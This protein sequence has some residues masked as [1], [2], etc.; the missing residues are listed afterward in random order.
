MNKNPLPIVALVIA[1]ALAD[2]LWLATSCYDR[3]DS[4][5]LAIVFRS[6]GL[7]QMT[8]IGMWWAIG[9]ANYWWRLTATVLVVGIWCLGLGIETYL[10]TQYDIFQV[11]LALALL[12]ILHPIIVVP[13]VV[14]ISFILR[15]CGLRR[16]YLW[17]RTSSL[18]AARRW[19]FWFQNF[20]K[21]MMTLAIIAVSVGASG[22]PLILL[23]VENPTVRLKIILGCFLTVG[24]AAILII[25]TRVNVR[26][27]LVVVVGTLAATY[28]GFLQVAGVVRDFGETRVEVDPKALVRSMPPLLIVAGYFSF[29]GIA[30]TLAMLTPKDV[31]IKLV[32]FVA[33]LTATHLAIGKYVKDGPQ[34]ESIWTGLVESAVVIAA[35]GVVRGTGFRVTWRRKNYVPPPVPIRSLTHHRGVKA[36]ASPAPGVAPLGV[37]PPLPPASNEDSAA[38]NKP[39]RKIS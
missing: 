39:G 24:T 9:L 4:P 31:W 15:I 37:G 36:S 25:L 23:S 16:Y 5:L 22:I 20:L 29:V 33:A 21:A 34:M 19:P 35:L 32:A 14:V 8:L 28:L 38:V 7:A 18:P 1:F 10:N 6:V 26:I 11:R 2:A 17:D 13:C 3:F 27:K 30:A 12:A